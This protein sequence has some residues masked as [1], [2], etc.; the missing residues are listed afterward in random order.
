MLTVAP[1]VPF[2]IELGA[3]PGGGY[4]WQLEALPPGMQLVGSE[5]PPATQV[6]IGSDGTQTFHLRT[7]CSGRFELRFVLKH[8]WEPAPLQTRVIDVEAR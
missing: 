4:L 7:E 2:E 6:A 3:A 8:G 1:G 5:F